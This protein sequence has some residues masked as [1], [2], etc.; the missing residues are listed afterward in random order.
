MQ[1]PPKKKR[2]E[3]AELTSE[4]MPDQTDGV[5]CLQRCGASWI[6]HP[7][8]CQGSS[9][10]EF[11]LRALSQITSFHEVVRWHEVCGFML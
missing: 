3:Q 7:W 2:L 1:P 9:A 5:V 6:A 11:G 4:F 8:D 10:L